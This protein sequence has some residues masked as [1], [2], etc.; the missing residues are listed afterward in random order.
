MIKRMLLKLGEGKKH[1]PLFLLLMFAGAVGAVN[2]LEV[3][4]NLENPGYTENHLIQALSSGEK[5]IYYQISLRIEKHDIKKAQELLSKALFDLDVIVRRNASLCLYRIADENVRGVLEKAL[6]DKDTEVR[7]YSMRALQKIHSPVSLTAVKNAMKDN[8]YQL[9]LYALYYFENLNNEETVPELIN[10]LSDESWFLRRRSAGMLYYKGDKRAK[11]AL[12]KALRDENKTVRQNAAAALITCGDESCV[13]ALIEA[14]NDP[15]Y[16]TRKN[17]LH[18]ISKYAAPEIS[19]PLLEKAIDDES[20]SVK[21]IAAEELYNKKNY[22]GLRKLIEKLKDKE[23]S[24]QAVSSLKK[25]T[26]E[27]F[28]ADYK[29]WKEWIEKK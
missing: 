1:L 26:G 25:I 17:A 16:K 23:N 24:S 12:L 11:S 2:S 5:N 27:D 14:G 13:P 3:L 8:D 18:T 9:R 22:K 7:R 28:G 6:K 19:I 10:A 21:N 15:Y 20:W 4:K 29:R